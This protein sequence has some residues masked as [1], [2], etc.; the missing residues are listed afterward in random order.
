MRCGNKIFIQVKL[1]QGFVVLTTVIF[2]CIAAIIFTS[3]MARLQ[4]TDNQI[5]GNYYRNSEAFMNAESG[6]N[7]ILS[8]LN[9]EILREGILARLPN[10][11][12]EK[13][14]YEH[15][16]NPSHYIVHLNR[17]NENRLEIVSHGRSMDNTAKRD[18]HLEVDIYNSS[19][20]EPNIERYRLVS[21]TWRDFNVD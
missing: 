15:V 2:L 18:I 17:V 13:P 3:N 4:L 11:Q 12:T 7:F 20:A 16:N 14:H 6:I 19:V 1:E 5:T 8:Q 10:E 21:G 9:D